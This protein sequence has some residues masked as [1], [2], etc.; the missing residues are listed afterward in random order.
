M[1]RLLARFVVVALI[2]AALPV[3]LG[4]SVQAAGTKTTFVTMISESG[5]W[6]GGG[7]SRLWR[8]GAGSIH[9]QGSL[10]GGLDVSVA[11]GPSGDAF[12]LTFAAP[13]GASL[14]VGSFEDAQRTSF[15]TAGHPGIDISGD[16][17]GC[18]VVEGSFTVLDI[19]PDLSRLW[20]TYE[21]HC[22]GGEPALFGEVKYGMPGAAPGALVAGGSIT[23]PSEYPGV[24]GRIVPLTVANTGTSSVTVS[25]ATITRGASDFSVAGNSCGTVVPGATCVVYVAFKPSTTGTRRGAL[26]VSIAGMSRTVDLAGDGLDGR[27]SWTMHSEPGDYI[28]AGQDWSYT[29][30]NATITAAGNE[31]RVGFGVE[32]GGTWWTGDFEADSGH[33]L[34][35][36]TTFQGATRYPFNSSSSPGMDVSGDGRGCNTLTGSFTVNEATYDSGQ[37]TGISI[38]FEQH[39]EGAAPALTGTLEWRAGSDNT[40]TSSAV[41]LV[42]S[43]GR[44]TYGAP[45]TLT[46]KVRDSLTGAPLVGEP[47]YVYSRPHGGSAWHYVVRVRTGAQ[48]AFSLSTRPGRNVD[49]RLYYFGSAGHRQAASSPVTVLVAAKVS[50][51]ANHLS[52]AAGTTFSFR[53]TVSPGHPGDDVLLQRRANDAWTTVA[54]RELSSSSTATFWVRPAAGQHT[55]RIRKP[56]DADHVAATS[57]AVTIEVG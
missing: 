22:E 12:D 26:T 40:V 49:Y 20:L 9:V 41:T 17:R 46:G 39:C 2:G 18:N 36:G 47:L 19:A 50:I 32:G 34:L 7:S 44:V 28:G 57:K 14:R 53:T 35:P 24:S 30:A 54:R 52:G 37:L 8:P 4:A 25:G 13:P 3:G 23:W 56:A 31:S 43:R 55:Y 10:A 51:T 1:V 21:E 15:R 33:L 11:G 5:D 16:G 27:T 6:V 38:T 42:S 45:A 48:G 29:P